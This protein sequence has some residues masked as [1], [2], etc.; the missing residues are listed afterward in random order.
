MRLLAIDTGG[1]ACSAAISSDDGGQQ[2]LAGSFSLVS[3][4][5]HSLGLL[6]MVQALLD[7]CGLGLEEMDAFAATLGPGSFTGLRIGAATVKAWALALDK[8]LISVSSTEAMARAASLEGWVCPLFDARR[9]EVY[10]AL[11]HNGQRQWPD[12]ALAPAELARRLTELEQPVLLAGD[13]LPRYGGLLAA[14]LGAKLRPLAPERRLIMAEAASLLAL[15]K[16]AAGDLTPDQDF[17]P[18]YLRKSEAEES[19]ERAALSAAPPPE[20]GA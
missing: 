2:A 15:D 3:R 12:Q 1:A 9:D 10:T 17:L 20:A 6:P 16:L 18:L 13:G 14:A 4:G 5:N 7:N 8:P 19:R 11:F